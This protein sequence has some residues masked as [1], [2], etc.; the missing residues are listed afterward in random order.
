MARTDFDLVLAGNYLTTLIAALELTRSGKKICVVNPLP[1]WGGHFTKIN[2]DGINFDPGAVSHEFTAFS[3]TG[4]QDP[5]LYTPIVR[6]DWGR[7][8]RL[9]EDYTKSHIDLVKM[10]LPC[11]VFNGQLYPDIIMTNKLDVL[12][13]PVLK[14]NIKA[15]AEF[16]SHQPENGLHAKNKTTSSL[17]LERSYYEA[18]LANHGAALHSALFEPYFQKMSNLSTTRLIARYHRI[19]WLPL[20]YPQTILSQFSEK[21]Q[22]F[23][24]TYF[25]Y[26][27]AGYIGIF[28]ETL[29]RKLEEAGATIV[30]EKIASVQDTENKTT[31]TLVNGENITTPKLIWSLSHDQLITS[32]T[33]KPA[34]VFER[35]S[36]ILVFLSIPRKSLLKDFSVLWS[37]DNSTL[38]YRVTNQT[39][40]AGLD[41][42]NAR[43][44]VELNPDFLALHGL[45]EEA[46]ITKR[47]QQDFCS[48]GFVSAPGTITVAGFKNLKNVL[49][50]P[51]RENWQLL[52]NERD[53]LYENYPNVLFTRNTESFFTD[54]MNDQIIKG[55]K[56]AAQFKD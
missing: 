34:N 38:F 48:L 52:E 14:G 37:P 51:S 23:H 42:L 55:L 26:P 9:I 19:G 3:D 44:V 18:S 45:T 43:I 24:E 36:A 30:R 4:I 50:L 20:Y 22:T 8:T 2:I 47:V 16:I 33:G 15:E 7:F 28:G 6:N 25:S 54:T 1:A 13:H 31:V 46:D 32:A 40:S 39:D 35:W 11:T 29:F 12:Q 27:K 41:E 49:L 17:F 53:I 56:I 5:L 21:P 10:K